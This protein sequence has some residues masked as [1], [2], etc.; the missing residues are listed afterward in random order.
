MYFIIPIIWTI[1]DYLGNQ[2]VSIML[3]GEESELTFQNVVSSKVS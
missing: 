2:T 3:N 1:A